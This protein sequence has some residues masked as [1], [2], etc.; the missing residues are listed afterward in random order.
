MLGDSV[1]R[2]WFDAFMGKK[3]CRDVG[4]MTER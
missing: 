2:L 1:T 4:H 3:S